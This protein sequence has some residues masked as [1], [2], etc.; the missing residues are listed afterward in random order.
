MAVL[1]HANVYLKKS[2]TGKEFFVITP[3]PDGKAL[4]ANSDG[5]LYTN[6]FLDSAKVKTTRDT[7]SYGK[8]SIGFAF[9]NKP[10][11]KVD[12]GF[13]KKPAAQPST[14]TDVPF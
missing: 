9:Y 13:T 14:G 12:G 2:K 4:I 10:E 8:D 7:N 11:K 6:V 3:T 5:N 1:R